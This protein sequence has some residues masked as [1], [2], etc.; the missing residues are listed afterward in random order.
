MPFIVIAFL[1]PAFFAGAM[2]IES[3]LSNK[4]F[5]HPTT[6]IF[7]ISLMN[8]LFLPLLLLWGTPT[9]P[10]PHL[11]AYYV[12]L[13]AINVGYL[14]P[15][16]QAMK[17]IDASIVAAL[18]SLGQITVPILSYF[19]L[20]ER[21]ALA[22]YIGFVIIIMSSIALS[23]KGNKIP[24]LNKAFYYMLF[25]AIIVS[26]CDI[27]E[28]RIL[29]EDCNWINVV[30]YPSLIS[31][32]MPIAFLG[33]NKW[34]KDII[35]NFPPYLEKFKIFVLNEFICFIGMSL[36]IYALSGL[37]P[38]VTTSINAV[39]PIFMLIFCGALSIFACCK[40]Q[41]KLSYRVVMKKI[42]CFSLIILGVI[43]VVA[44]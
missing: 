28:K 22:Q 5:R 39:Q 29:N 43:L 44:Y 4:T 36:G 18:F 11:F 6:M 40:I 8:A 27:I 41:E 31:G 9:V 15:Y 35:K 1:S 21:L 34:R 26:L 42:F 37:S 19:W 16:Y 17:V 38:V 3:Y 25:A 30:I 14:Y 24:K 33:V 20:G 12:L 2:I 32:I 7:Y 10:S 23:I 13:G